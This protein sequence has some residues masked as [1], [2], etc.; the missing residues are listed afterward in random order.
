MSDGRDSLMVMVRIC[1][2]M[3]AAM[4]TGHFLVVH[5][6]MV[7][8]AVIHLLIGWA[9]ASHLRRLLLTGSF[10]RVN[11]VPSMI[12]VIFFGQR[13]WDIQGSQKAQHCGTAEKGVSYRGIAH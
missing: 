12:A 13:H 5:A 9:L 11:G 8:R 6:F 10:G 4:L 1:L 3:V 2:G 7:H